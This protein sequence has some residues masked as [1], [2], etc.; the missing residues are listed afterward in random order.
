M[1]NTE[2]YDQI[3]RESFELDESFDVTT[4]VYQGVEK[5]DSVGHMT[6]VAML[7]ETF[8][9]MMD[10]DDIIDFSSYEKGK[11]ILGKYGIEL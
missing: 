10:T 6:M 8:D 4:L 9:I 1:N 3:M 5:W 11:E 2:K 7:E